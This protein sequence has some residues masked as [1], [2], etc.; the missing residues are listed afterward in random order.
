MKY[1]V[2]T[3][4]L[5]AI[6]SAASG[7]FAATARGSMVSGSAA[8][9]LPSV[10][11]YM[12]PK[13]VVAGGVVSGVGKTT[14]SSLMNNRECIDAYTSCIKANDA[15]GPNFEECTT[16]V[17]F[18]GQMPKCLSILSQCTSSGINDLFG[19]SSVA[20]FSNVKEYNGYNEVSRYTYPTDGSVLGQMILGAEI[21]NRYDLQQCIKKTESC[22]KKESVC[23]G[24][25]ELCTSDEEFKKQSLLC[26]STIAR[27]G[28]DGLMELY[29]H[30]NMS[31][32]PTGV[33]GGKSRLRKLIDDGAELAA[34]NAV[35][36]CY[37]VADQCILSACGTNPA[38]CMTDVSRVQAEI[39]DSINNGTAAP[40]EDEMR[41]LLGLTDTS[42]EQTTKKDVNSYIRNMCT[43][44]I[45]GNKYCYMTA[46][47]GKV[48]TSK[49]LMEDP[50]S[51]F[52]DIYSTR[53]NSAMNQRL[54]DILNKFDT[55]AKDKCVETFKT[56]AMRSCGGGIGS[57]CY[58]L[59]FSSDGEG[60]INGKQTYDEIRLG[61]EAAVNTDAN[62]KYALA[63]N[64]KNIYTYAYT[65]NTTFSTLF[66][67]YDG[68]NSDPISVVATLNKILTNSY[69][70]A[71][72]AEMK[73]QCTR[74]ATSCVKS[75]CGTNYE[76]CYRNRTD[77][78]LDT[79][80]TDNDAF[81]RSMNKAGGVLDYNVV[82]GLCLNTIKNSKVCDE[83]LKIEAVKAE[84]AGSDVESWGNGS[85]VRENWLNVVTETSVTASDVT[86]GCMTLTEGCDSSAM[87]PCEKQSGSTK[88]TCDFVD[89][90]GCIYDEPVTKDFSTY[91]TDTAAT[92]LLQQV[93]IDVER[94]AQAKYTAELNRQQNVC[95]KNNEGGIMGTRDNG[96][97]Y[98]WVKLKTRNV[99]GTYG[100]MGLQ[101]SQF[102]ATGD[103]YGGFC[104]V[105]VTM[106]S[107]KPEAQEELK[108][109]G[110]DKTTTYFA[111]GDP[112]T[113]GSW[114]DDTS[115][116]NI[117]EAI[118]KKAGKGEGI[119][120]F[121]GK[122][123]MAWS[124]IGGA[125]LGGIGGGLL[126]E[127]LGSG[128]VGGLGKSDAKTETDKNTN[129]GSC[130]DNATKCEDKLAEGKEDWSSFRSSCRSALNDAA[131]SGLKGNK[132]YKDA[133]SAYDAIEK[134]YNSDS[135]K[136]DKN[137]AAKNK[138][139]DNNFASLMG[140]LKTACENQY[141]KKVNNGAL[142]AGLGATL[143]GLAGAGLGV[144]IAASVLQ[145]QKNKKMDAAEKEWMD[146]IGQHIHCYV[147]GA[148]VGGMYDTVSFNFDE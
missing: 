110:D 56:C 24:D 108:K 46:N 106:T 13:L 32:A 40:S 39:I 12:N 93:L 60:T 11:G 65:D 57:A 28:G 69:N 136:S 127:Y 121:K 54:N 139:D 49:D 68:S 88:C 74:T 101:P 145:A 76:K 92:N 102:T 97:T 43:E 63:S 126:G 96:S 52:E 109:L 44:T 142:G 3:V 130:V 128:K 135:N 115:L 5:I 116:Q 123:A 75:M 73:K 35:S 34:L 124:G 105:K 144:G 62:C 64:N 80:K 47:D 41:A 83:H 23:G 50:E 51:V 140:N 66:P 82:T 141:D 17:L 132:D 18:H 2:K 89:D 31:M 79:Y 61:C 118:R 59:V 143:G 15:C 7:A 134:E 122:M 125:A 72:I 26:A 33:S 25:F 8:S 9:R 98:M 77:I 53:M 71:A 90:A 131:R 129:S 58:S 137:G 99:P 1:L 78:V 36:T 29:G 113:C 146:E 37:K 87:K 100:T 21:S 103:V 6:M 148:R 117:T 120:S 147:G 20:N 84:K 111:V 94:E 48:P 22:L 114:L 138:A 95:L 104:R 133:R 10:S 119:N 16:N 19:T 30:T 81:N 55:K 112:F 42:T 107:D 86:V 4:S 67:I 70:D 27:C 91:I 14:A 85:D 38:R 45:G